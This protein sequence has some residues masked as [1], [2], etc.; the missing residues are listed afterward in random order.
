[1]RG[2]FYLNKTK[3]LYKRYEEEMCRYA[4]SNVNIGKWI[5]L[6]YGVS[7]IPVYSIILGGVESRVEGGNINLIPSVFIVS[8]GENLF[9]QTVKRDIRPYEKVIEVTPQI[10]DELQNCF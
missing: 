7:I 5:T 4:T 1:M 10:L 8:R 2:M 9:I 6:Q 3:V